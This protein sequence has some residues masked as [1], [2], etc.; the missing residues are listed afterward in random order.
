MSLSNT[1]KADWGGNLLTRIA[2][3]NMEQSLHSGIKLTAIN[4]LH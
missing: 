4:L 1:E 2:T 3:Q